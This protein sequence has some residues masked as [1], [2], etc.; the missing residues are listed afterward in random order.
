MSKTKSLQNTVNK[1]N[2]FEKN[3]RY[4]PLY[5]MA[6][7]AIT[8]MILYSYLPMTGL[9][10]AF[11]DFSAGMK[12]ENVSF[13][14]LKWFEQ[15]FSN[16][17][18]AQVMY[19]TINISV[20]KLL[21]GFPAPIILALLLN[22]MTNLKF[23]RTVQT[24]LYLPHFLSW[25]ILAGILFTLFSAQSGIVSF[26][27]VTVSIFLNESAF[28]PM[29]VISDI[30]K[31][32]GWGTIVYLSAISAISPDYY[33]A[34]MID[35]ANRFQRILHITIPCIT[36]TII[37]LLIMKLGTILSAGFD[38]IYMLS[39]SAVIDV[40]DILDT[41]VYRMGMAQ[42]RFGLAT[43]AGL[44]KSVICLVLVLITNRV[45]KMFDKEQSLF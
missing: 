24:V 13:V 7:P 5:I 11:T 38:Q 35:G 15:I 3:R 22:E 34:A 6:L 43:A 16:E 17:E 31:T 14:G 30:W 12:L 36:S 23:K 25:T 32:A 40:A 8:L 18:F 1:Q 21:F 29:I 19:N 39:N 10:L 42:G 44:F 27:G 26:F 4:L 45:V 28:V 41:Y 37:V 9:S 33:E 20:L 2:W